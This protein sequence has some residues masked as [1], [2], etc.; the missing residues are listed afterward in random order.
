MSAL[1]LAALRRGV[2]VTGCDPND[3]AFADLRAAG[4]AVG[5]EVDVA[6][7]DGIRAV[8]V[9]AAAR[10]DHPELVEARRRG[11]AVVPRKEALAQL[12][13]PGTV[14]AL[15]GTHG[16]T[17]TTVMTTEA[18]T[19]AGFS[20]SGL[21]GGRVA[22]WG[23]NALLG[24][25]ALWVVEADEYD[26]AF[27][28]LDPTVAVINNVEVDH[29]EC[30]GTV[31]ALHEAFVTFGGRA[32][33]VLIGTADADSDRIAARLGS[34]AIRFGP[35]ERADLRVTV[36]TQ[37]AEGSVAECRWPDGARVTLRLQVPGLHNIRNAVAALGVV[38]A[39][40]G[41]LDSAAAALEAFVGVGRRFERLGDTAGITFVD[42]YA[43]HPTEIE[44]TIAA[45][46]QAFPRRRLVAVFQPHLFSRTRQHGEAMGQ[47]L[48]AADLA[49]ITDVYPAREEPLPGVTGALVVEAARRAGAIDPEYVVD[50]GELAERVHQAIREG[51]VVLT[52]GAGDITGVGPAVRRRLGSEA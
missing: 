6:H 3:I 13:N 22:S 49:I 42:D 35:E 9:T 45:A 39:L 47:A 15:A 38:H 31:E 32:V 27:L 19:A 7:L 25:D 40:G 41:D 29:L 14:V 30:Y 20:P 36:T 43:H 24:G 33:T 23:G 46:R 11:I 2:P 48:S 17:T 44:A 21:A 1:A 26:Q 28:T 37:D 5:R 50:R 8:V 12:V 34:Q 10:H 4:A 51:D 16:K 18:L 52:L